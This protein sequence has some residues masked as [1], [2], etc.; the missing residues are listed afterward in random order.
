MDYS[1]L[2]AGKSAYEILQAM[3]QGYN[4]MNMQEQMLNFY[5]VIYAERSMQPAAA[6]IMAEETE[7]MILVTKQLFL[8]RWHIR[9]MIGCR[10]L[11]VI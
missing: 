4:Q 7:R 5:K 8:R 9:G 6:R 2:F 11:S 3:V 1:S 10:R